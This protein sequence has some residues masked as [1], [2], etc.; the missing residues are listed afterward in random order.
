MN[1]SASTGTGAQVITLDVDG[2]HAIPLLL[3][4]LGPRARGIDRGVID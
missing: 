4:D 2:K 1:F 3:G